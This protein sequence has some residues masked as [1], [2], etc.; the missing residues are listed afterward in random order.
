V[1]DDLAEDFIIVALHGPPPFGI[2]V[3]KTRAPGLGLIFFQEDKISNG[4][5]KL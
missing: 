5:R 4:S 2:S 1:P 3:N